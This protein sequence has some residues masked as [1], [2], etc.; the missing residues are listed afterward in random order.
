MS[1]TLSNRGY[2]MLR[3]FIDSGPGF[4]MAVSE[5]DAYDQRPFGSMLH[6]GW[7]SYRPGRGFFLTKEGR[8]AWENFQ[9]TDIMRKDRSRPLTHYFDPVAYGLRSPKRKDAKKKT[10][11]IAEISPL[12]ATA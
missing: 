9:A 10:R 2:P 12:P 5:A 7:I 1:I 8:A 3:T 11:D 6:R 4:F